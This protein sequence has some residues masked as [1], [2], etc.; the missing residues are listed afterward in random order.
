MLLLFACIVFVIFI[1]WFVWGLIYGEEGVVSKREWS[2][3]QAM[4]AQH[5]GSREHLILDRME[6]YVAAG[7]MCKERNIRSWVLVNP[8]VR[9]GVRIFNNVEFRISGEE[10]A[11]ISL[12]PEADPV[13][14]ERLRTHLLP[15]CNRSPPFR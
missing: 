2:I 12:I 13:V 3:L 6:G 1:V 5:S 7:I 15:S 4:S 8:S 14:L 9:G 11:K 10:L